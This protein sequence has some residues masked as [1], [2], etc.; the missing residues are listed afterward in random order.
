MSD[1][2]SG[3]I[4]SCS[5]HLTT[6]TY[7]STQQQ[8][9]TKSCGQ[10]RRAQRAGACMRRRTFRTGPQRYH[11]PTHALHRPRSPGPM[12][13]SLRV[14][15]R[16]PG[17]TAQRTLLCRCISRRPVDNSGT[18]GA[19][20]ASQRAAWPR[21]RSVHSCALRAQQDA[22]ERAQRGRPASA[23]AK[24]ALAQRQ[25]TALTVPPSA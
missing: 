1:A 13:Q 4:H 9:M 21:R 11:R 15:Q 14:A 2:T 6:T 22:R 12:Q 24:L 18:D 23:F 25:S 7:L 17:N 3:H 16:A 8:P 20:P 19:P 10:Q 5:R